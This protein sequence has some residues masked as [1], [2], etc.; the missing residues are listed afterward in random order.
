MGMKNHEI[1]PI[2]LI[3]SIARLHSGGCHK[4]LMSLVKHKLVAYERGNKRCKYSLM[5]DPYFLFLS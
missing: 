4:I 5:S 3:A 2:P 1:V